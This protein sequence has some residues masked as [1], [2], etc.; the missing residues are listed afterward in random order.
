[1]QILGKWQIS[2]TTGLIHE[3]GEVERILY[4]LVLLTA[5][6]FSLLPPGPS[7]LLNMSVLTAAGLTEFTR[8]PRGPIAARK[9][10]I[11]ASLPFQWYKFRRM[12]DIVLLCLTFIVVTLTEQKGLINIKSELIH[13]GLK[14]SRLIFLF[15][16]LL[17]F[18]FGPNFAAIRSK[19]P[20]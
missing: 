18:D 1:M 13:W 14:Y 15:W 17:Y 8:M 12:I 3:G 7:G 11:I 19:S 5:C 9:T 10:L 20:N 2:H 16:K 6:F 4:L